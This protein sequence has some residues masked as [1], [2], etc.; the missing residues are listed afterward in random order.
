MVRAEKKSAKRLYKTCCDNG[1]FDKNQHTCL[2][3]PMAYVKYA[4][5]RKYKRLPKV[6]DVLIVDI[7]PQDI[8]I[9]SKKLEK[10]CIKIVK[11]H[12][13]TV[14]VNWLTIQ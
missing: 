5:V 12:L 7:S 8:S 11:L 10:F 3:V 1:S 6:F 9:L 14:S 4:H 13:A 2:E